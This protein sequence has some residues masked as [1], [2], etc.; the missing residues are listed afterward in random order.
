MVA[1][2]CGAAPTLRRS[3]ASSWSGRPRPDAVVER[4]VEEETGLLVRRPRPG[5]RSELYRRGD[6]PPRRRLLRADV[7]QAPLG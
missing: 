1:A 5:A 4:W 7:P 2:A 6:E 3:G